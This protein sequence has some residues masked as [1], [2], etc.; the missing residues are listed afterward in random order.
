M[1]RADDIRMLMWTAFRKRKEGADLAELEDD[2]NRL[3][4][5]VRR[6]EAEP[7]IM[8]PDLKALD[9]EILRVAIEACCLVCD[10]RF[11][12]LRDAWKGEA[13]S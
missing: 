8:K 9:I 3:L 2:V 7:K 6:M 1:K 11:P 12:E 10:D 5:K 13:K 4:L